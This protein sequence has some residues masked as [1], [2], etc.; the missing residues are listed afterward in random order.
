MAIDNPPE[1]AAADDD[2]KPPTP[3]VVSCLMRFVS[4]L[5]SLFRPEARRVSR[6]S[7]GL[8]AAEAE[9]DDEGGEDVIEPR[10]DD[11][12]DEDD[13]EAT[14]S[15]KSSPSPDFSL[16]PAPAAPLPLASAAAAAAAAAVAKATLTGPAIYARNTFS[17]ALLPSAVLVAS[18]KI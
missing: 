2:D 15:P 12:N 4:E 11:E 5:V 18:N 6:A 16:P 17:S 3:A 14:A 9:A 7:A 13:D 8:R 10:A 1:P